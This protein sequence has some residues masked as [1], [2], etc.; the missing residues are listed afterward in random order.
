MVMTPTDEQQAVVDA[1]LTGDNVVVRALAGTGKTTTL[2][3]AARQ[4]NGSGQYVA[5]NKA[6]VTDSKGK[7]PSATACNTAHSLAFRAVGHRYSDRL[8][9]SKRVSDHDL[10]TRLSLGA[11]RYT[12]TLNRTETL[13]PAGVARLIRETVQAFC[14]SADMQLGESHVQLPPLI[15]NDN[16]RRTELAAWMLPYA[17]QVWDDLAD[18]A[19]VLQ[20]RHD[21]YLKIWQ[22]SHPTITADYILFDEAQDADPV[23]LD[24]VRRQDAQLVFC[25]DQFQSIYQWRGA[26]DAL[27]RVE[28]D[29]E[30]WLTTTFRYGQP[31][32]DVANTYLQL[33][34]SDALVRSASGTDSTIGPVGRPDVVLCRTNAGVMSALLRS[35]ELDLTPAVVGGVA[36]IRSLANACQS[37]QTNGTTTHPELAPF[38]SWDEVQEWAN[39]DAREA[40]TLGPIIS[41]VS[42]HGPARLLAAIDRCTDDERSASITISTAHKAKGRE[43]DTVRL[44][45]DFP[46]VND[47]TDEELRLAYVAVTRGRKQLDMTAWNKLKPNTPGTTALHHLHTGRYSAVRHHRQSTAVDPETIKDGWL[48][49]RRPRRS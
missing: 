41:L 36:Q 6:I 28:A 17:Q 25:G 35:L 15:E 22:L 33:L 48:S 12:T 24:V 20:F 7:F 29:H 14:S 37:L 4:L 26:V 46:H 34:D 3:M 42:E 32:A 49:R 2:A 1:V 19:G 47:M 10:A 13:R 21:H 9:A 31:I 38:K 39:T 44:Y 27:S 5:F 16:R 45:G 40:G 23:M 30:R 11:V 18:P 43:W 8:N